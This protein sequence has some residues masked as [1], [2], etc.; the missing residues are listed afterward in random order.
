MFSPKQLLIGCTTLLCLEHRKGIATSPSTDLVNNILAG[1]PIPEGSVD[2]DH[3][4]QTF[5][6]LRA[7][8]SWLNSKGEGEFPTEAEVLQQVQVACREE[9]YLYEALMNALLDKPEDPQ[10]TIRTIQSIRINLSQYLNEEK[11]LAVLKDTHHKMVFKRNTVTDIQEEV[12]EM[13]SKLEPLLAIRGSKAHP[14]MMGSM[15]F[16]DVDTLTQYLE[17]VKVTLSSEGALQSGWKGLNRALGQTGAFRRGELTIIGGLQHHFKSG[18]LMSLFVHAAL[19]NK[20]VMR[21]K[22]RKPLLYFIS[23]ENEITDNLLWIYKYLKENDDGEAVIDSQVN[24]AEA[25]V[26]VSERLRATGFEI[27]MDRYDPTDFTA[28]SLTSTLEGLIADG[29]EIHGLYLDYLNM[30]SKSGIEAK[31][32]GDDIRF[33]FRKIRNFCSPRGIALFSPHQLSSDALQLT[34][35][36]VDDFVKVIA[37]RG[38]YDGCRRLGQ[39]PDLELM[40]H[41]VVTDGKSYLTVQRGKH[42]NAVTPEKDL[43]F[44]LP[45]MPIGTIPWDVDREDE[46]TLAQPGGG[47]IGSGDETPWW[48]E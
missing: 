43:Y 24:V 39:E 7:A 3:G 16:S 5:L 46:I 38:Y 17:E 21:D 8:V 13:A 34:R 2:T 44:V 19:F 37:N 15:D 36:N 26:Y 27:R 29:Y 41:K 22:A 48:A 12:R 11:I 31:V 40:I 47:V 9:A 1:L 18:F 32:A 23:F 6:E 30:I 4:R 10:E 14:A 28:T 35:D 33:L 42:R 25:S 20:P 45:F